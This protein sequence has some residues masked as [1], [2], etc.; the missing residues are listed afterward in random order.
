[1]TEIKNA[2]NSLITNFRGY[3]DRL[4]LR[5]LLLSISGYNNNIK[6]WNLKNW[7]CLI[8]IEKVNENGDLDSSCILKDKCNL[9]ILTS[10][11]NEKEEDDEESEPIKVFDFNGKKIEEIND[12]NE[13]AFFICTYY[14]KKYRRNYILTGNKGRV[15]SYDYNDNKLYNNYSSENSEENH[16]SLIVSEFDTGVKIIESSWDKNIRI[17]GFH[18]GI[19]LAKINIKKRIHGIC[20]WTD[21]DL[22]IGCGKSIQ[23][24][25]LENGK[26]KKKISKH[27]KDDVLTLKSFNHPQYGNCLI[28][29]GLEEG[30]IKLLYFEKK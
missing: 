7:E 5:D 14:D 3:S 30:E 12:S 22:F 17:W 27:H 18:D 19:L 21:N 11:N 20:L 2:H 1:M 4:Y 16:G 8:N 6:L 15:K 29:Q 9:Y 10:N 24:I 13:K 26:I 23:L 25:N 28:S